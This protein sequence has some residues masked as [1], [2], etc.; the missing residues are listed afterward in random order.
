MLISAP[1]RFR[2]RG[3]RWFVVRLY[4]LEQLK[5]TVAMFGGS[6][7]RDSNVFRKVVQANFCAVRIAFYRRRF[8]D[9]LKQGQFRIHCAGKTSCRR[10]WLEAT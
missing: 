8:A 3:A 10:R 4:V 6:M 7:I 5:K 1:V 2:D 9:S